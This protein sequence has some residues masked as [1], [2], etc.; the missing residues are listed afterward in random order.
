[1]NA[2]IPFTNDE[3]DGFMDWAEEH[4]Q[5][6]S[7]IGYFG[8]DEQI[9][10]QSR[11][12]AVV[13]STATMDDAEK[14]LR[15]VIAAISDPKTKCDCGACELCDAQTLTFRMV[16]ERGF[17]SVPFGAATTIVGGKS[18]WTVFCRSH[19]LADHRRAQRELVKIT[20]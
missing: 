10:V 2:N 9:P 15:E 20:I 1:M 5:D 8:G 7:E 11:K 4:A 18:G 19:N 16:E 3:D 17:P 13:T 12:K 14:R 6:E